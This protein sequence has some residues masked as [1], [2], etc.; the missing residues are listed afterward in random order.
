MM[1]KSG[2]ITFVASIGKN[3][4]GSKLSRLLDSH[5]IEL[6]TAPTF[7]ELDAT[8]TPKIVRAIKNPEEFRTPESN[9]IDP[10]ETSLFKNV[11]IKFGLRYGII[12]DLKVP[13][14]KNPLSVGDDNMMPI[15]KEYVGHTISASINPMYHFHDY[16]S[17]GFGITF[18]EGPFSNSHDTYTYINTDNATYYNAR[19][20]STAENFQ[21]FFGIGI[22][23]YFAFD[24]P[25]SSFSLGFSVGAGYTCFIFTGKAVNSHSVLADYNGGYWLYIEHDIETARAVHTYSVEFMTT[26]TYPV[27]ESFDITLSLGCEFYIHS[28]LYDDIK[29]S[30]KDYAQGPG[31]GP[32]FQEFEQ[33]Y[34]KEFTEESSLTPVYFIQLGV[35][36]K[37]N[38]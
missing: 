17:A 12:P 6:S 34:K 13:T 27:N 7:K 35:T 32:T 3:T 10:R 21:N 20:I 9:D 1:H 4:D 33:L 25:F 11:S 23:G 22:K 30:I 16:L 28:V 5:Y 29:F 31:Y 37:V 19:Q 24:Y 14:F 8:I 18:T 36:Y 15:M 38:L 26:I 2:W